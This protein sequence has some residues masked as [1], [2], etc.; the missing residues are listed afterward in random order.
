MKTILN[1]FILFLII[2]VV[3]MMRVTMLDDGNDS[4][5]K[6]S[7]SMDVYEEKIPFVKPTLNKTIETIQNKN[8]GKKSL[9]QKD[10]LNYDTSIKNVSSVPIIKKEDPVAKEIERK[11]RI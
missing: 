4:V 9:I 2:A 7:Y 8:N 1:I 3:I 10:E 11:K 6:S 5:K